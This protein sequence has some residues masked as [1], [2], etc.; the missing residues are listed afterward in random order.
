MAGGRSSRMGSDKSLIPFRDS[1]LLHNA[2][3][4][5]R[6]AASDVAILCGPV[7]RYEDFGAR[8][9]VDEAC[10]AGPLA[11][12]HAA[13]L[14]A[15]SDGVD[16]FVWLAVDTPFVSPVLL[17]D[18]VSALD[19]ADVAMAR[20][21]RGVE[22]LCAAFRVAPCLEEVRRALFA[23][24]LKLTEALAALRRVERTTAASELENL[25]TPDDLRRLGG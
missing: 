24:R 8:I 17:R 25:N 5:V 4:V 2:L 18:L 23:G 6:S 16:R 12:L 9:V 10:G 13:L 11:G 14:D 20:T 1:T 15:S 21:E 19:E 22:P 7:P 3:D